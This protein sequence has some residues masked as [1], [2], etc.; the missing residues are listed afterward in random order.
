M[1][2][3][4]KIDEKLE[5]IINLDDIEKLDEEYQVLINKYNLYD[6]LG[7]EHEKIKIIYR[8]INELNYTIFPRFHFFYYFY[9]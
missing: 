4:D 9:S 5:Q 2:N 3:N 1:D 8:N 6:K 7:E